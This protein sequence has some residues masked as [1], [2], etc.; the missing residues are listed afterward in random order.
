MPRFDLQQLYIG[1]QFVEATSGNMFETINPDNGEVLANVQSASQADA[2][3]A[4]ASAK[5][6]PKN[7]GGDDSHAT[8]THLA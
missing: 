5:Q 6:G 7:L 3:L 2:D 4:V 1:G 8:V